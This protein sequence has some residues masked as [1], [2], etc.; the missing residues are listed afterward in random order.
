LQRRFSLP[1]FQFPSRANRE[2]L[3]QSRA[4]LG[5]G[6]IIDVMEARIIGRAL[7]IGVRVAGRMAGKRVAGYANASAAMPRA[8]AEQCG[9]AA[10]GGGAQDRI[11]RVRDI[12]AHAAAG[13]GRET[14]GRVGRGVK[15]LLRPFRRLGRIVWLEVTG[16]FF[17][18]FAGVFALRLWQNWV[19][20]GKHVLTRDFAIVA[21]LIFLYLGASSFWRARRR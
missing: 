18:L 21:A 13:K 12:K 6:T 3:Q 5:A 17:L 11:A 2:R 10:I 1:Y 19:E 14:R 7:G 4:T 16:A 15:G 20:L 8:R 9:V